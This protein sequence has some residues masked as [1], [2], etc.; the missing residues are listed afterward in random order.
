MFHIQI[1]KQVNKDIAVTIPATT[2]ST[3]VPSNNGLSS[4]I[5]Y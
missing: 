1:N 3:L 5:L 2:A 4:K